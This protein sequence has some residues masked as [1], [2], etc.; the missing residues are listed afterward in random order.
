MSY[1]YIHRVTVVKVLKVEVGNAA[2]GFGPLTMVVCL[3]L[4]L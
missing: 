3:S 4:T 2:L 1:A